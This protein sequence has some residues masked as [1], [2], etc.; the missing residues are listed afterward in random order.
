MDLVNLVVQ[1]AEAVGR[2]E[3]KVDMLIVRMADESPDT[4]WGPD[5]TDTHGR[6]PLPDD[7]ARA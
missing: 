6:A 1:L 2:L 3:E 7:K 4:G 5:L